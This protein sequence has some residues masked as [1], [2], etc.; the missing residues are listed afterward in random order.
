MKVVSIS[1][2]LIEFD[3]SCQHKYTDFIDLDYFTG[4]K[5]SYTRR[6]EICLHWETIYNTLGWELDWDGT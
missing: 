4:L 1:P 5:G 2:I 6:C 3:P